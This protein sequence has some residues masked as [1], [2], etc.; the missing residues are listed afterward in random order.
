MGQVRFEK[1]GYEP[2]Q[3]DWLPVPPPQL[4]VNIPIVQ[5]SQPE[6]S[7]A[8]A[9]KDAIDITFDKYMMPSLLNTD[10]IFVTAN[11]QVIAGTVVMRDEQHPYNDNT[12]S[13]ATKVRFVPASPLT[14]SEITL[15]VSNRVRSYADVPMSN[16]FQQVFDIEGSTVVVPAQAPVA[17]IESGMTVMRGEQLTLSCETAGA[18]IRYTMDGSEPDC[19]TGYVYNAP[20]VL[21]G[22]GSITVKAIACA[23]GYDPSETAQ[24]VYTF[25]GTATAV[26]NTE[27]SPAQASKILRDGVMYL[28]YEGRMYNVQGARVK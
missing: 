18:V 15:T 12:T 14:V 3:S 4:E 11:D 16:T 28:M 6:V 26:G 9:R 22:D 17:S 21:Y 7:N 5:L 23:D 13:F 8:T 1:A 24:W 25:A 10:N 19:M 20:I 2:A 27:A